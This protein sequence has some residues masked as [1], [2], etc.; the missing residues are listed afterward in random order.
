MAENKQGGATH[1]ENS[2]IQESTPQLDTLSPQSSAPGWKPLQNKQ[3]EGDTALAL[4]QDT[5]QLHNVIN[6]V[7]EKKLIKKI[8][9]IILPCLAICYVF[10]YIDKTTLSYAAIFGI[11]DDLHLEGTKYSWLSSI[12]YFGWL[13]W[14]FPTNYLMQKFPVAKYLAFNI[15][16]WG[17]LLMCQAA[18]RNFTELAVLRAL[19]GAAEGCSDS[20]F[21]II[22]SMWYTRREQPIRIGLW[23]SANGI[24]IAL[25]GLIG[26]SIGNIR[27]SLAS[28]KYEFLI[29]GACCCI[30]GIVLWF[31]LPDSPVTAKVLSID[32]KRMAV[33]RLRENQT[34]VEN[35]TFKWVQ[36]KEWAIDYKTYMFFL[37]GMVSNVPNG[38]I[39]NFG[40]LI[41]RGF[42]YSTQG[43]GDSFVDED[44][45]ERRRRDLDA[46][47]FADMTDRENLNFRYMF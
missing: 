32:E 43:Q 24:G 3:P 18:A 12:F 31:F 7:E 45:E 17:A 44:S 46:T 40:T 15:F 21:M 39:S 8:D 1:L 10:Y 34:G 35:K 20:S 11:K 26:Y 9:M 4:F 2:H 42:G 28:W 14:S 36:V 6:P 22:T 23:Y 27:G 37:I 19:S 13:A 30:W 25:G 33:E 38:G 16:M 41:I 5:E 29:V 47:A